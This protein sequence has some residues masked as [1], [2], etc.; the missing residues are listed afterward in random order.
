MNPVPVIVMG[1]SAEPART[2]EGMTVVIAGARFAGA[3]AVEGYSIR[4][5]RRRN[6]QGAICRTEQ[7]QKGHTRYDS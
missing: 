1:V 5:V 2:K 6:R 3:E 4:L 7:R